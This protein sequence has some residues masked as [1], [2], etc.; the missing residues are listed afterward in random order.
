[1]LLEIVREVALKRPQGKQQICRAISQLGQ[2]MG[3]AGFQ[4]PSPTIAY[5]KTRGLSAP[6]R[7][8]MYYKRH[9]FT[10]VG[11]GLGIRE[12]WFAGEKKR[13]LEHNSM[14]NL[15]HVIDGDEVVTQSNTCALYIGQ[16]LGIDKAAHF[17]HNHCVLD[18]AMDL[19]NSLMEFVYPHRKGVTK[20][21]FPAEAKKHL[22]ST[23][24][25]HLAKFEG[26]CKGRF[27][28]GETPQSGDFMLF[29]MIDQHLHIAASLDVPNILGP[30]PKMARLHAAFKSDAALA[31]YFSSEHY[32]KWSHNTP[33]HGQTNYTG[34]EADASD[35]PFGGKVEIDVR[36]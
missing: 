3:G 36:F 19:R 5:H 15:P 8:M 16:K 31:D 30:F 23:L 11:Y 21:S 6:L 35:F 1:M 14:I 27:M 33:A 4:S 7:M 18:Q 28:C 24:T 10:I 22:S 2:E 17:I 20:E 32:S 25:T 12:D 34:Q 9:D 13:L 26:F 29:E